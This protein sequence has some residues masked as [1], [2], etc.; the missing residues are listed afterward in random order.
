MNKTFLQAICGFQSGFHCS[1]RAISEKR[2]GHGSARRA[3][4]GAHFDLHAQL[5]CFFNLFLQFPRACTQFV[6]R[7]DLFSPVFGLRFAQ[8]VCTS[9]L[10]FTKGLLFKYCFSFSNYGYH[11]P[12]IA[13]L[14]YLII[15]ISLEITY[16]PSPKEHV[17]RYR[18][19]N[20]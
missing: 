16:Q 11:I 17:E 3:T 14:V 2:N 10:P 5:L 19:P 4:L 6:G 20:M 7:V 15:G 8:Q 12:V 1:L 13:V 9:A 18:N